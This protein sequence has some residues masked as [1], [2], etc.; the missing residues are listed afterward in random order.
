V[1]APLTPPRI[2]KPR[3]PTPLRPTGLDVVPSSMMPPPTAPPESTTTSPTLT[4]PAMRERPKSG[5]YPEPVSGIV[6]VQDV[7][8]SPVDD[9]AVEIYDDTTAKLPVAPTKATR[10]PPPVPLPTMPP[11]AAPPMTDERFHTEPT[12]VAPRGAPQPV[13]LHESAAPKLTPTGA[14]SAGAQAETAMR[15]GQV[16]QR[17][18]VERRVGGGRLQAAGAMR[19]IFAG[20]VD[21]LLAWVPGLAAGAIVFVAANADLFELHPEVAVD[22]LARDPTPVGVAIAV[23]IVLGAA[24]TVIG[25]RLL[26]GTIGARLA[27]ADLVRLKTGARPSA[28]RAAMCGALSV[29]GTAL[30]IGPLYAFWVDA[31]YRGVGGLLARTVLVRRRRT[32]IE[33]RD[34]R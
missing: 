2:L 29:V 18:V 24:H 11:G 26:G 1:P 15:A 34:A 8:P 25:V 10:K 14:R 3:Q 28:L 32:A 16:E 31:L 13:A 12:R 22:R 30:A 33:G 17:P 27:G 9:A 4:M 5:T 7:R 20:L 6:H 19:A 23:A 21:G